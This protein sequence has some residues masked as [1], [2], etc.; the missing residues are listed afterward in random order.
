M[1]DHGPVPGQPPAIPDPAPPAVAAGPPGPPPPVE[2][3]TPPG[4]AGGD[5]PGGRPGGGGPTGSGPGGRPAARGSGSA[6]VTMP[7]RSP[8]AALLRAPV[9]GETWRSYVYLLASAPLSLAA[10]VSLALA[11]WFAG[12]LS[13]GLVGIPLLAAIV[14]AAREYG[15]LPRA[16]VRR[17]L[18]VHVQ[19]PRRRRPRRPGFL[20]WLRA[21]LAD[22]DGWRAIAYVVVSFPL[23][24]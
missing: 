17:L 1:R 2:P 8:A 12:L 21:S 9:A 11:A 16:L 10:F 20:P 5:G 7:R 3:P 15:A 6:G 24:V 19:P 23:T 13:L 4:A 14:L 18:G 22:L